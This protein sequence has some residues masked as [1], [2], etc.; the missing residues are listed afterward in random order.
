[1]SKRHC[2]AAPHGT[3]EDSVVL[4]LLARIDIG[5]VTA[6]HEPDVP[7]VLL[8]DFVLQFMLPSLAVIEVSYE[9]W[10]RNTL[11]WP[12]KQP[13]HPNSTCDAAYTHVQCTTTAQSYCHKHASDTLNICAGWESGCCTGW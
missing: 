13:G 12:L 5:T 7:E 3:E 8:H 4:L 2:E 10:V 11:F 1:M 9:V 6:I